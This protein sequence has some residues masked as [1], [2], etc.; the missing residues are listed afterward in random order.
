MGRRYGYA[1]VS[2]DEQ[3]CALQI[4]ALKAA[5]C[6]LIFEEKI[7]GKSKRLPELERALAAMTATDKIVVWR[8]DRLGRNFRQLVDIADRLN[9]RSAHIVSLTEGIDT[10]TAMGEVI[11]RI[12]SVFAD[13]EHKTIVERT[14]A[15][16]Q[17]AKS[18]GRVLGRRPKLN[19]QQILEVKSLLAE[20][21]PVKSV[22]HRF[23]VH[24]A[25][26]FRAKAKA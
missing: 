8:L 23:G 16:L 17:A 7:S 18:R 13:L 24:Q 19:R 26:V 22:A 10:S 11:Y 4:D 14:K 20:G 9:A 6:D 21:H 12:I 15:G 1:R 25:T 3:S 5:Q 2:T